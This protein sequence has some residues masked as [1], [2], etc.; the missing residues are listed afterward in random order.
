MEKCDAVKVG[1]ASIWS[2]FCDLP[3]DHK[4]KHFDKFLKREWMED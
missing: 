2:L 1:N 4:G 3:K